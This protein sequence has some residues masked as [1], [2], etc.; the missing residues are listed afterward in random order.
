[1]VTVPV[2]EDMQEAVTMRRKR[3]RR[4]EKRATRRKVK[5]MKTTL[6]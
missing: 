5:I 2:G 1:V 3:T 4:S 6:L